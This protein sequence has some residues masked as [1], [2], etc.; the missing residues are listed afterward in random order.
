MPKDKTH[1]S[2]YFVAG[3]I[4]GVVSRTCIAPIERVKILRQIG[5]AGSSSE[6]G[7]ALAQGILRNEGWT[8][9]WKGNTAAV[10][11][12]MPYMSL[13]FL[14]YEEYRARFIDLGLPKQA[15]TLAGGSLGGVT[16]VVCTYPLDLVRATMATPGS[17]H[18]S[19]G[20]ALASIYRQRGIAALYSGVTATCVGVAPYAGLKFLSYEALKT[21]IGGVFGLKVRASAPPPACTRSR[22]FHASH[23][24]GACVRVCVCLFACACRRRICDLGSVWARACW[25]G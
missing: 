18:G 14:T 2:E 4:A 6:S 24:A 21:A 19:M 12:V 13:T 7:L 22:V 23:P 8:A 5:K 3:G 1:P 25:L 11:R 16:A 17:T 20:E 10:V 9:F 15:A